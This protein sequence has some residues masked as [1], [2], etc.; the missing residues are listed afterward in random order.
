MDSSTKILARDLEMIVDRS[1][2][3][4]EEMRGKHTFITVATICS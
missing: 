2:A 1:S 4:G 3:V